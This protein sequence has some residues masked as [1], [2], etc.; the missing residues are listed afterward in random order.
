MRKASDNQELADFI[1]ANVRAHRAR[2]GLHQDQVATRMNKLG[3]R[4]SHMT[5]S[6]IE[7]GIRVLTVDEALSLTLVFGVPLGS[8][9]PLEALGTR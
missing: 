7:R 2:A 9:I 8:V 5:V 1:A 6:D 4:W 3:H